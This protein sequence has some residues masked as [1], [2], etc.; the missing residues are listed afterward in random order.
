MKILVTGATGFIGARFVSRMMRNGH[1]MVC[2]VRES[3]NTLFL[4]RLGVA[5][6]ICDITDEGRF[7]DILRKDKP[8]I[9]CHSAALVSS[10][11]VSELQKANIAGTRVVVKACFYAGVKKLVYVSS[12][13]VINGNSVLPLT[14]EMPYMSNSPYG[15]SKLEAEKIVVKYRDKGLDCVILRPCMI[16]GEDE[17]HLLDKLFDM[18]CKLPVL[19]P[20]NSDADKKLHLGYVENVAYAMELAALSQQEHVGTFIIADEDILTYRKF[21]EI[22]SREIKGRHPVKVPG[23]IV[24]ALLLFP[25]LRDKYERVFRDREFDV[26]RAVDFLGYRQVM[27]AEEA[28]RKTIRSWKEQK[29]RGAI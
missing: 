12:I 5:L 18:A 20:D 8:D 19:M 2:T 11:D 29:G 25:A 28:L 23:W 17:P 24:K 6:R 10:E 16:Y 21:L 14:D 15:G 3:S 7:E 4:D 9:V 22:L 27:S 26:S 13:A 1:E